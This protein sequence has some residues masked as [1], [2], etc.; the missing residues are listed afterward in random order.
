[1]SRLAPLLAVALLA[2]APSRGALAEDVPEVPARHLLVAWRGAAGSTVVRTRDE[3]FSRARLLRAEVAR[4]GADFAAVAK[5]QSDD[6]VT[7][8]TGGFLGF[9]G[10]GS[11]APAVLATARALAPGEVSEPVES[12]AGWHVVLRLADAEALDLLA[13]VSA[14]FLGAR[15]PFAGAR[16]DLT[17]SRPG[18]RTRDAALA[19]ARKAADFVRAG[20]RFPDLPKDLEARPFNRRGW[21]PRV[22]RRGTAMADY[23]AFEDAVF[24]TAVGSVSD[25]IETPV[26]WVVFR[27]VPW[28]RARVDHLVVMHLQSPDAPPAIRRTRTQAK[29]R[30]EEALAKLK[31]EPT[32]WSR[33]VA[34]YSD[35]RFTSSTGGALGLREPGL[36]G[37]PIAFEL[38]EAAALMPKGS[39]GG[40]VETPMGFHVL[41]RRD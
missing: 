7:A 24:A 5:S 6:A 37:L 29:A 8:P 2:A 33:I 20:T 13:T 19:A 32:S 23:R 28:F 40:V 21:I 18:S 4:P 3:A 14:A 41:R 15:F 12:P 16:E 25:P 38:D 9:L 30:A 17:A 22:L 35:D 10:E 39:I 1:M 26:G 31:A 27:R 11:A 34:E 36:D